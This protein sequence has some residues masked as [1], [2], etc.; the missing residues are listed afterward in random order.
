MKEDQA[1]KDGKG[2]EELT[3]ADLTN[4]AIFLQMDV[5]PYSTT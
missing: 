5:H 4:A 1:N 2:R 3:I